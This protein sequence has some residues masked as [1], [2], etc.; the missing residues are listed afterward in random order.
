MKTLV[1]TKFSKTPMQA[2]ALTEG[3]LPRVAP[4]QVLVR[5]RAAAL[6]PADLHIASGEM[7]LMSPVKPPFALGVDGAGVV[8]SDGRRFR[9]GDRVMV[10]T[11]LVHCGTLAEVMALPEDRLAPVP[12]G[13]SEAEAAAAPLALLVATKVLDRTAAK[14]GERMLVTAAGGPVGAAV[15]ALAVARGLHVHGLGS[16]A[17]EAYVRS[18]GAKDYTDYR[19]GTVRALGR[20]FDI[21]LD[22]L[23]GKVFDDA[24]AVIRPGGRIVSLK[25][26]TGTEDMEAMGMRVPGLMKLLLPLV[27][28]KQRKAAERAGA[29]LIGLASH[30]DGAALERAAELA[31]RAGYRPRIDSLHPLAD[32]ASAFA[33]LAAH[34]RGKV[35]V[36]IA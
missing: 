35:V 6:N 1:L 15:T 10:Y 17:D 23:G 28:R 4:S 8:E 14:P 7:K 26:M 18:L 11:G 34:P 19:T 9:K 32:F 20:H 22:C 25:V 3:P 13:W 30:Q 24:A 2:M 29:R 33:R 21:A 16:G 12:E 27:F 5:M 31:A 36:S